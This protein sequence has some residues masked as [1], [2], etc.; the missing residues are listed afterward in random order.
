MRGPLAPATVPVARSRAASFDE[1]A[2][3]A[4]ARLDRRWSAELRQVHFLV[5]DVPE[6]GDGEAVPLGRTVARQPGRAT[7]VVLYRRP[8]ETR[9]P[10]VVALRRLVLNVLV[11]QVAEALGLPPEE[12]DSGYRAPD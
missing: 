7:R 2:T 9:A 4:V 10:G 12:V 5:E 8:I 6:V 3:A 11:E 1:I